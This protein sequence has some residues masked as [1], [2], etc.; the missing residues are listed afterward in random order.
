VR[1]FAFNGDR[2][3]NRAEAALA[4]IEMIVTYLAEREDIL[5]NSK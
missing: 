5:S 2:E 3:G 4:A 1:H